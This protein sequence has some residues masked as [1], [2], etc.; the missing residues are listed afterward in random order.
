M[1]WKI[2]G[3]LKAKTDTS[4]APAQCRIEALFDQTV[5]AAT[6]EDTDPDIVKD[7]PKRGAK[8]TPPETVPVAGRASTR[9]DAAGAF[10]LEL[11]GREHI[12]SKTVRFIVAAPSGQTIA[13][14][15]L[16]LEQIDKDTVTIAV[17][18]VDVIALDT[19]AT[20]V[21]PKN[22][23]LTGRVIDRGGKPLPPSLQ[24]LIFGTTVVGRALT[25]GKD[26][27]LLAVRTDASGYFFG[28]APNETYTAA[29]AVVSGYEGELAVRLRDGAIDSPVLLVID[30]SETPL[31]IKADDCD[32]TTGKTPPRTPGHT[33]IENA[34]DTYSTDLGTGRCVQFN[35]PNRSIEEFSFYTVV[36]TTEPDIRG[37]TLAD[38]R[39]P[40]PPPTAY[41]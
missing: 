18:A 23:R 15:E 29:A 20:P 38:N 28:D 40:T 19:P 31:P 11:P 30:A 32:C 16:T 25:V 5:A 8:E 41:V 1:T 12:A 24:V 27:P 39:P 33:E 4:A 14:H 13:R 6:P 37:L 3:R 35:T 9:S 34:P 26:A 2:N 17:D 10:I 21:K 36:R 22:V 7:K